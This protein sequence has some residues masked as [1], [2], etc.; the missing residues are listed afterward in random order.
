MVIAR[1]LV[2]SPLCQAAGRGLASA[3][4]TAPVRYHRQ[5][6]LVA[7]RIAARSPAASTGKVTSRQPT[8]SAVAGRERNVHESAVTATTTAIPAASSTTAYRGGNLTSPLY[9]P[10]YQRI[11]EK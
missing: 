5:P 4:M 2:V 7:A 8:C 6:Q 10:G 11:L 1:Q 3:P 9:R